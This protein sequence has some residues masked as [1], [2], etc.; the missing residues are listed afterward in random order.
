V[1]VASLA[2]AAALTGGLAAQMASGNDPSLAH[3]HT[4]TGKAN[5]PTAPSPVV[6]R[7]S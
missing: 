6:T 7:T 2:A 3:K 5:Q 4:T 1:T